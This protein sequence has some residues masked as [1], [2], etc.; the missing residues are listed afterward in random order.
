MKYLLGS[1]HKNIR[2]L[3][4]KKKWY[5]F[6][7][8]ELEIV[9]EIA[10]GSHNL[11]EL[12][13]KLAIKPNLLTYHLTKLKEKEVVEVKQCRYSPQKNSEPRKTVSIQ[14]GTH[15]LYLALLFKKYPFTKWEKVLSGSGIEVLFQM[16][17]DSESMEETVPRS[18]LWRHSKM[19]ET[20]GIVTLDDGLYK[21]KNSYPDLLEF[22]EEYKAF[23]LRRLLSSVSTN[24]SHILWQKGSEFLIS[25]PKGKSIAQKGFKK[26]A[27]SLLPSFRIAAVT[28]FDVYLYSKTDKIS[29]EETILHILLI[30]RGTA[31]Y[32]TYSYLLLKKELNNID[33]AL[34]LAKAERYN[35]SAEINH[36]LRIVKGP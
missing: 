18:T 31:R 7:E 26:A 1:A 22:M 25:V 34:L 36:I 6:N 28:D 24:D 23:T 32:T 4:T 5:A 13:N 19:L 29:T 17:S 27:T 3:K 33:E 10:S 14:K 12:K 16:T 15:A 8:K 20:L 11:I 30:C 2:T 35:L 9:R 21:V